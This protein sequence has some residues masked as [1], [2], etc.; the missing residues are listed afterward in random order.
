MYSFLAVTTVYSVPVRKI[1]WYYW[2]I[3]KC[4][5]VYQSYSS[6]AKDLFVAVTIILL[7]TN[8]LMNISTKMNKTRI[9]L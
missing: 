9:N 4:R 5:E 1:H 7:L 2:N 6:D 3:Q 8:D